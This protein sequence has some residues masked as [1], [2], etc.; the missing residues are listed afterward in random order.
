MGTFFLLST[1][2]VSNSRVN[3]TLEQCIE[4][5]GEPTKLYKR[6]GTTGV[7]GKVHSDFAE[8][9]KGEFKIE[10]FFYENVCYKIWYSKP[11][12]IQ[13]KL[14]V[15]L[16][17]SEILVLL[18]KNGGLDWKIDRDFDWSPRSNDD[19]H[20]FS[21]I[22]TT[23]DDISLLAQHQYN[24]GRDYNTLSIINRKTYRIVLKLL[25]ADREEKK[26][27]RLKEKEKTLKG[28]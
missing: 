15:E 13:P 7:L 4:R 22:A 11:D 19:S 14:S 3:E 16:S 24:D 5:Y 18:N 23:A 21:W 8:F 12:P 27:K 26:Q 20:S 28:F 17:R 25:E 10:T 9:G 2:N 6:A 1:P